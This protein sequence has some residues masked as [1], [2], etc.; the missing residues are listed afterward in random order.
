[1]SLCWTL[2]W[3]APFIC[4]WSTVWPTICK[5]SGDL[6]SRHLSLFSFIPICDDKRHTSGGLWNRNSKIQNLERQQPVYTSATAVTVLKLDCTESFELRY[7]FWEL[8]WNGTF[9]CIHCNVLT[10]CL[11]YFFHT[12]KGICLLCNNDINKSILYYTNL[13]C[14][15]HMQYVIVYISVIKDQLALHQGCDQLQV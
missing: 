4:A 8:L 2:V 1:M 15:L 3:A 14:A 6:F 12:N 10:I 13:H 5:M 11:R 7:T 9:L